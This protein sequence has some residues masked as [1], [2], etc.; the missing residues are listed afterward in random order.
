MVFLHTYAAI[1]GGGYI[2]TGVGLSQVLCH[3]EI[4]FQMLLVYVFRC[5]HFNGLHAN[6]HW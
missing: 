3:L 6:L 1:G 5:K 2:T 4:K